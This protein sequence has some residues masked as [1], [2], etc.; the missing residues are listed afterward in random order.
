MRT[1]ER[2]TASRSKSKIKRCEK[3]QICTKK[4]K[5]ERK[6]ERK[7]RYKNRIAQDSQ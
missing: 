4:K 3:S 5:K 6:K 1:K 7:K 2:R